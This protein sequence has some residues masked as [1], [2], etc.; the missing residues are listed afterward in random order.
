MELNGA[1]SNP[2]VRGKP[3]ELGRLAV[4]KKKLLARESARG[5]PLRRLPR[6]QGSVLA[7]VTRVLE[8]AREPMM[9]SD[10]HEAVKRVLDDSVPLSTVKDALSAH[11][12]GGDQ[13][14]K[15]V[16]HGIYELA[17]RH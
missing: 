3:L 16:R 9:M 10:I 8:L 15:R 17:G 14:F 13:R 11:T 5:E 2:L 4:L 12:V 1:L 6:R 7:A